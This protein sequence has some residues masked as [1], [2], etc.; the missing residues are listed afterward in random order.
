MV[1][2]KKFFPDGKFPVKEAAALLAV[3]AAALGLWAIL[4]A[5]HRKAELAKISEQLILINSHKT[6]EIRHWLKDNYS[7]A[8]K[9]SRHPFLGDIVLKETSKP[10]SGSGQLLS[11]L[12]DDMI[13]HPH[14]S[15]A[16]L[17]PKGAVIIATAGYPPGT[18]KAFTEALA[19]AAHGVPLLT[20]LY[21]AADGKPRMAILAPV[22]GPS[23]SGKPVCVL[24]VIINPETELYPL[25][26]AAPLFYGSAET[27]LVR[28]EGDDVLF[29]N[30][31]D[32]ARDSALK[33]RRPLADT[34]L[35]AAVALSG[36]IGFFIGTDYRGVKVFSATDIIKESNWGIVTKID[37]EVLLAAVKTKE[38]LWLA[39]ILM[40]AGLLYSGVL[41]FLSVRLREK[42]RSLAAARNLLQ[43]VIDNTPALVYILDTEERFVSVNKSI[44][45]LFGLKTQDFIG[46]KRGELMPQEAAEH[47]EAND[48]FVIKCGCQQQFEETITLG[49]RPELT[50]LTIKFPLRDESGAIT[51]IGGVSSDITARKQAE[52]ERDQ[53]NAEL[54]ARKTDMEN[55]IY[56]TT[57]DLRSPLVNIQGFGQ[58]VVKNCEELKEKIALADMPGETKERTLELAG[59]SIPEALGFITSS[60]AKMSGML[61]TLLKMSR[62]GRLELHAENVDMN[63]ALKTVQ[64]SLLY[65]LEQAGGTV[66][67]GP[68]PPCSADPA[69]IGQLFSNLLDNAIKYRDRG[70]KLEITVSGE[71]K[72]GKTVLY[73]VSDNGLGIKEADLDKIWRIFYR[74]HTRVP[75]AGK[76]EGIGL[77]MVKRLA[78]RS[79]GVIRVESK[80]GQGTR[81]LIELPGPELKERGEENHGRRR[82]DNNTCG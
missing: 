50:F 62:L 27:L 16:L 49:D 42:E 30:E 61:D 24:T 7:E 18:E 70:R 44:A 74:G 77:T 38:Y 35:P 79:G 59:K 23:R 14:S 48:R 71:R 25:V 69:I 58:E 40:A 39:L 51:G 10:G 63:T 73:T 17:S 67:I 66:K 55:F 60:T 19:K 20:D 26:K 13:R 41:Y 76:G 46:K 22:P 5:D 1:I 78:E 11:W 75:G 80:E 9:L 56:I 68:L 31:L 33:L 43:S 34:G 21:L 64:G 8:L 54:R 57:H 12:K 52:L 47:H 65:Q 82:T 15:G 4:A 3:L 37:R 45:E 32:H 72:D 29:L 81:F 28:R 2:F 36:H 53:L 6:A